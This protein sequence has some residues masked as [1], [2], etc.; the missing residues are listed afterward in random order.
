MILIRDNPNLPVRLVPVVSKPHMAIRLVENDHRAPH[1]G[2]R[3]LSF[4]KAWPRP[5]G[6]GARLDR[7]G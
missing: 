4:G 6:T 3:S 5:E 7:L 2:L 1:F